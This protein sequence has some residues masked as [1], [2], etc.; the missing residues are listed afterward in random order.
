MGA[1]GYFLMLE[2]L[3]ALANEGAD[4]PFSTIYCIDWPGSGL[5]RGRLSVLN[6]RGSGTSKGDSD[7]P[8]LDSLLRF[9]VEA[10]DEWREAVGVGVNKPFALLGHSLGGYL[11]FCY[12]EYYSHKRDGCEKED[13]LCHLMLVS[14]FG[15]GAHPAK[16][17]L[18]QRV[19]DEREWLQRKE[20]DL[21]TGR[22]ARTDF[23]A[24][25]ESGGSRGRVL[26][27]VCFTTLSCFAPCLLACQCCA[28]TCCGAKQNQNPA[29]DAPISKLVDRVGCS[30]LRRLG[31]RFYTRM[32]FKSN[33]QWSTD[34]TQTSSSFSMG[35]SS[36]LPFH[37]SSFCC[38][39]CTGSKQA[40]F[41]KYLHE[42][43]SLDACEGFGELYYDSA[44]MPFSFGTFWPRQPIGGNCV[45]VPFV[46]GEESHHEVEQ[47]ASNGRLQEYI[48]K[49]QK[50]LQTLGAPAP[51]P[52]FRVSFIYGQ[53]D[54]VDCR[55]AV[56][57]SRE[58]PNTVNEPNGGRIFRVENA[59]H[60][61]MIDNPRAFAQAVIELA[62]DEA[63][64]N[65]IADFPQGTPAVLT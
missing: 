27:R 28:R 33:G 25:N 13:N 53:L 60:Q 39:F 16:R 10:I 1:G 24:S 48:R 54:W 51:S 17:D 44:V 4:L 26:L 64:S 6:R 62:N 40:R 23:D 35:C 11:A 22:R 29:L 9:A 57:I 8:S 20:E 65:E 5:S 41:A 55:L 34:A 31:L 49:R 15:L 61:V 36:Y 18:P 56:D 42:Y 30:F 7:G 38:C 19:T 47:P 45:E 21:K 63:T 43:S 12:A 52:R 3:R 59:G 50:D 46:G 58:F 32:R 37:L 14:P 2:A